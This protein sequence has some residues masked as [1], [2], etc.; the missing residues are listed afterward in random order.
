MAIDRREFL[1]GAAGALLAAGGLPAAAARGRQETLVPGA[2]RLPIIDT[3][4]HLWD[5]EVLDLEWIKSTEL[6]N[7]SYISKDYLVAARGLPISKAVYMEVAAKDEELEKE[8]EY[9]LYVCKLDGNPTVAAVIG[10]RPGTESFR[11]YIT[12]YGKSPYV[13]GVRRI[14]HAADIRRGFHLSQPFIQDIRL[15]GEMG[16]RFDLNVPADALAEGAK[17]VDRCPGTPFILNHC[18][19][20]DPKWFRRPQQGEAIDRW[21]RGIEEM[22]RRKQVACKISGIIARVVLGW[23][24]VDLAPMVNHCLDSFGPDRVVFASDWPVCLRGA[25]LQQWVVAL[26]TVIADRPEEEHRKLWHDNA[27]RVYGLD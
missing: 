16:L 20:A 7:R 17:L 2:P 18:G 24:P 12:R 26:N 27:R 9:A 3:H 14:L 10:G 15:L 19:N 22:A 21:R 23:T 8:A 13:K 11:P 1:R 4:Q 5:K 25:T 6:L